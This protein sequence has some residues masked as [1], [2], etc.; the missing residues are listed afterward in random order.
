M[1]KLYYARSS[2]S[3]VRKFHDV[4]DAIAFEKELKGWSRAKKV[5]F[6]SGTL[7]LVHE[8]AERTRK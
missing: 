4:T 8:L 7:S 3:T 1:M 2:W 5:A 6:I